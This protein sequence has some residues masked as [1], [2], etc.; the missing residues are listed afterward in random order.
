MSLRRTITVF[1]AALM[2]L[3]MVF[4][5]SLSA[6][7]APVIV[8]SIPTGTSPLGVS[9]SADGTRVFNVSYSGT[10]YVVDSGSNQ[11]IS[12]Y[13]IPGATSTY[14]IEASPVSD[15]L[16]VIDSRAGTSVVFVINVSGST[17]VLTSTISVGSNSKSI[18]VSPDGSRVYIGNNGS[19]D[20]SV[21]VI[22]TATNTV[23]ATVVA[24]A[25][26]TTPSAF[27]DAPR[28]MVV[29]PDG[30][31]LYV[32]YYDDDGA[33]FTTV[34]GLAKMSTSTNSFTQVI[35]FPT[36]VRP[37]GLALTSNGQTLYMANFGTATSGQQWIE[38]FLTS[39]LTSVDQTPTKTQ[40]NAVL[41]YPT[42]I[43]LSAD[44]SM[45]FTS[46]GT[47]SGTS[48]AFNI[49]NT[50]N[51]SAL[52]TTIVLPGTG[53]MSGY[54]SPSKQTASHFA[55]VGSSTN[56]FLVGEYLSLQRQ[57]ITG[58]TGTTVSSAAL[59]AF[60]FSG[61]VTY[62]ISPSLPAGFSLNT[63]T[64]IISGSSSSTI[65]PA[66]FTITGTD[67]ITTAVANVTLSVTDPNS[68][69]G[70][71]SNQLANTGNKS[72]L[73]IALIGLM[74]LLTGLSVYSGSVVVKRRVTN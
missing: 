24:P 63:S 38:R 73:P 44:D 11:V 15:V 7:A 16:Y 51:M 71:S 22:D 36:T 35:E 47:S 4:G 64:G 29:S 6:S 18:A 8:T 33:P 68:T 70:G 49:Y 52:P 21:S 48:G 17:P 23:I 30:S 19:T 67:G 12:S 1:L 31:T 32:S 72:Q 61:A 59:T 60:G 66:L 39:N 56:L 28:G 62:S 25:A 69:G 58:N 5:A 42:E 50:S 40:S 41:K 43:A 3:A 10:L 27:L 46:F 26:P 53:N 37:M 20:N 54:I 2:S 34:P 65:N 14:A 57:T 74:F 13:A 45:L 55:Y 9:M